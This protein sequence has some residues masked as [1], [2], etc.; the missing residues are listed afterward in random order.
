MKPGSAGV[1]LVLIIFLASA[2]CTTSPGSQNS[3]S[4]PAQESSAVFAGLALPDLSG[5]PLVASLRDPIIGEWAYSTMTEKTG[6]GLMHIRFDPDGSYSE[7]SDYCMS[8]PGP[9][10]PTPPVQGC[11]TARGN[12]TYTL[13]QGGNTRIWDYLEGVDKIVDDGLAYSR[14]TVPPPVSYPA[15]DPVIGDWIAAG[16]Q[17]TNASVLFDSGGT[18]LATFD[19][20]RQRTCRGGGGFPVHGT[21]KAEG[22]WIYNLTH[23]GHSEEWILSPARNAIFQKGSLYSRIRS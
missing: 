2:G 9:C 4:M 18:Y 15:Q 6:G 23:D 7:N 21:W 10:N 17:G 3:P 20:C 12:G 13:V 16:W 1:L 14:S 5:T 22:K 8:P 19:I 11:W